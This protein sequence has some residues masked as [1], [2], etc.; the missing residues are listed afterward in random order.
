[1]ER[2]TNGCFGRSA[3]DMYPMSVTVDRVDFTTG[4]YRS[5]VTLYGP[6]LNCW[7]YDLYRKIKR[8]LVAETRSL[9]SR[10]NTVG[11]TLFY[12]R[13]VWIFG[14]GG[15]CCSDRVQINIGHSTEYGFLIEQSL[16]FEAWFPEV[17][18]TLIFFIGTTSD[19]FIEELHERTDTE[20]ALPPF[21][22]KQIQLFSLPGFE[23]LVVEISLR[24]IIASNQLVCSLD[25]RF[26]R[27]FHSIIMPD[28]DYYVVVIWEH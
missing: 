21:V 28:V 11:D 20:Q 23:W 10:C 7:T 18:G 12:A 4:W 15:H 26:R 16:A 8:T 3:T 6:S 19:A 25:D 22:Y 13:I 5:L 27:V 2:I 1:M 9:S 24:D 14:G 17:P